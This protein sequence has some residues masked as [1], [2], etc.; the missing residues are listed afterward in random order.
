MAMD[1]IGHQVAAIA[2]I[3]GPHAGSGTGVGISRLT[4]MDDSTMS[5]CDTSFRVSPVTTS[6]KGTPP[7][8][9]PTGLLLRQRCLEHGPDNAPPSP[10]NAYRLVVLGQPLCPNRVEHAGLPH[11]KSR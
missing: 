4:M 8:R 3:Q 6:D 9:V 7:G 10:D 11:S 1:D 5:G 2:G